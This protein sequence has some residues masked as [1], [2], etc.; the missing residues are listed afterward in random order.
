MCEQKEKL[1]RAKLQSLVTE[2][3]LNR[4]KVIT[5]FQQSNGD[6]LYQMEW[7]SGMAKKFYAAKLAEAFLKAIDEHK[8][9]GYSWSF[10]VKAMQ[11][12]ITNLKNNWHPQRSSSVFSNEVNNEKYEALRDFEDFALWGG[13]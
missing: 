10:T 1:L 11:Q 6:A 12:T 7:M 8:Q 9:Q 5:M 13:L 2:G 3:S 4:A